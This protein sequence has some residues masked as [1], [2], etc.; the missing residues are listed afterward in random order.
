MRLVRVVKC[1]VKHHA[2]VRGD[3]QSAAVP[4]AWDRG[5]GT[6]WMDKM[7]LVGQV[8]TLRS[9]SRPQL[10]HTISTGGKVRL[11]HV[12]NHRSLKSMGWQSHHHC[13]LTAEVTIKIHLDLQGSMDRS[14]SV[15]QR[16][17]GERGEQQ[18]VRP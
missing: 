4:R 18:Q 10:P 3:G 13:S 9:G 15:Y 6:C 12:I 2:W 7:W 14:C 1:Q 5:C 16:A 11:V 17:L 8:T